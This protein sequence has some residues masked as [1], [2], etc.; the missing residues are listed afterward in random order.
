[1]SNWVRDAKA[2][3]KRRIERSLEMNG[4][5]KKTNIKKKKYCIDCKEP[6]DSNYCCTLCWGDKYYCK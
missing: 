1:M 2:R 4:L 5:K 6:M 3:K